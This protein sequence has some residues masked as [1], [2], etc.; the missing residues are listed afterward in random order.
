MLCYPSAIALSSRALNHLADL[1]RAERARRRGR[2][3]RLDAGRQALL[4]LA[5]LRIGDTITRLACGCAVSVTTAWR[6]AREAID[7]PAVHAE[8]LNAAIRRVG[9]LA[10]AI[11]DGTL[12]PIDRVA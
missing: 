7:L 8:T 12:I 5:Q 6:Y 4:A 9:R 11:L 2:W 1:I 10:Y 3:R